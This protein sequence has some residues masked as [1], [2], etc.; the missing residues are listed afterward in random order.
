MDMRLRVIDFETTATDPEKGVVI[1]AGITETVLGAGGVLEIGE[2]RGRLF[3]AEKIPPETRAVHHISPQEIAGLPPFSPL[4][5][6]GE[7]WA[8][9]AG[10]PVPQAFVA[11]NCAFERLFMGDGA[12][13][14]PWICTYK[15][16][17]RLW[18][19]LASHSNFALFYWLLDKGVIEPDM[20]RAQP[21]HRAAPDTYV[22][23]WNLKAMLLK[24]DVEQMIEWTKLPRVI[25]VFNFGK[26]KG[27][28][29]GEVPYDYLT[30]LAFKSDMDEDTK[31]NA[32][33][34]IERRSHR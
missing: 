14:A 16:A 27:M 8:G 11:H 24:A 22:T 18:P 29:I 13:P 4:E 5:M 12:E 10:A 30:W 15:V 34:E 19:E 28:K 21:A 7:T 2:T 32:K 31:W 26:H 3:G 25:S 20:A 6:I 23:A 33:Q 1:E 9:E 17:L